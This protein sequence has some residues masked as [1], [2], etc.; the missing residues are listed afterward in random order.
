MDLSYR[1][2]N[3]RLKADIEHVDPVSH[4]SLSVDQGRFGGF[5]A[6]VQI[7]L[8]AFPRHF[9]PRVWLPIISVDCIVYTYSLYC[10][11][12]QLDIGVLAKDG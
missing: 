9:I 11:I 2:M 1:R 10:V 4:R 5:P 8:S 3:L 12:F 7:R 6:L